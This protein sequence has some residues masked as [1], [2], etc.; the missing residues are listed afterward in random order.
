MAA[1]YR[2]KALPWSSHHVI[3]RMIPARST[4]LDVGCSSGYLG[5]LLAGRDCR[6]IGVDNDRPALKQAKGYARTFLLDLEKGLPPL[7][8]KVDVIVFADVLEHLARP[9]QVLKAYARFL[10]PGGR[11]IV[12]IPN[13]A[14]LYV[15]LKLL[16]GQW[17]YEDVGILDRTHLRFYTRATAR[18]FLSACG[19][20]IVAE[21]ATPIPLELVSADFEE[22]PLSWCY[23]A[24]R[25]AT[26]AWPSLFAF[27]FVFSLRRSA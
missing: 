5:T 2:L 27:Q 23:A 11:V 21:E 10:K 15:R 17:N 18:D 8:E 26:E 6:L 22:P 24:L 4:V 3:A 12:S 7:K 19:Y 9:D 16:A 20:E 25:T 13:V 14:N 1:R